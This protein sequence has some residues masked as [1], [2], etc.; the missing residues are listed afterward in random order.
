MEGR[1]GRRGKREREEGR[2]GKGEEG[3]GKEARM[4]GERE[5]DGERGDKE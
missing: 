4:E 1:K 3:F 2:E 5:E